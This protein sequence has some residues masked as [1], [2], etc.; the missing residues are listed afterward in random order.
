MAKYEQTKLK[1]WTDEDEAELKRLLKKRK[2]VKRADSH[3]IKFVSDMLYGEESE[4]VLEEALNGNIEVKTHRKVKRYRNIFV[5]LSDRGK[6][7]G[8]VTS[9]A[10]WQ[11]HFLQGEGYEG[12]VA[13]LIKTERLR[14]ISAGKTPVRGGDASTGVK[15]PLTE[16][17]EPYEQ[18]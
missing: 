16:L 6:P 11:A 7:S 18:D 12:E 14:R 2:S 13:V 5:E 1:E 4:R 17:M 3:D 9:K 8:I 15:V 10:E